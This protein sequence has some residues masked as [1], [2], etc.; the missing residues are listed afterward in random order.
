MLLSLCLSCF[1]SLAEKD[2][3]YGDIIRET[4]EYRQITTPKNSDGDNDNNYH[5]HPYYYPTYPP[6]YRPAGPYYRPAGSSSAGLRGFLHLGVSI[7]NSEFDYDDIED[8]DASLVVLG[9]RPE[10]SRLGYELQF[11]GSGDSAVTSLDDIEIE[12]RS[13]NLVLSLNSSKNH[14]SRLNLFAK[15]GIYFAKTIL[16]GPFDSVRENSNGFLIGAG[17]DFMLNRHFGLKAEAYRLFDVEDFADDRPVSFYNL[18]GQFV[19]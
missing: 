19:F 9:Y 8:G 7:G 12:V 6:P 4:P 18:G 14:E 11:F 3:E 16:S 10:D 5:Y 15:G 2:S 17:I 13:L 1:P